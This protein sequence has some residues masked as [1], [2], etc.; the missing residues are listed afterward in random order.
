MWLSTLTFAGVGCGSL[1]L[2]VVRCRSLTLAVVRCR[3]L[4]T[5]SYSDRVTTIVRPRCKADQPRETISQ[6]AS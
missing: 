3:S 6:K 4:L 2:A 1:T 5:I